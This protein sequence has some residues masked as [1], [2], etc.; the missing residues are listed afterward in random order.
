MVQEVKTRW[1]STF[2]MLESILINKAALLSIVHD[3]QSAQIKT[4]FLSSD[5]FIFIE[6]LCTLLE[7]LKELTEYLSA[8]KYVTS[9]ML[10]PAL[11]CLINK[12]KHK[13]LY[14]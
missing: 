2:D 6:D 12:V 3:P 1:N 14:K 4:R 10:F 13:N 9:C 8:T 5:E 11:Y 7:P